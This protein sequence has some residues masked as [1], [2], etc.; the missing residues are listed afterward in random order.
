MSRTLSPKQLAANRANAKKSTGPRTREGKN[1]ASQNAR[2]H[3]VTAQTLILTDEAR[4]AYD[5]FFADMMVE[6]APVGPMETFIAQSIAQEA[7]RLDH[8]RA[9]CNN[10]I[11]IGHFD[12]TADLFDADHP[13]VH[14]A[15]TA[16]AVTRDQA[17][18]L[19]RLSLYQQ[20]IH[21][22]FQK[23]RA[24]LRKLQDERKAKRQAEL[25]EARR[26]SQLAKL[27]HLPY[28]PQ[29][30]GFDFSNDEIDRAIERHHRRTLAWGE[31]F[32]YW[33]ELSGNYRLPRSPKVVELKPELK[34]TDT[35]EAPLAA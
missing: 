23:H 1:R 19:E 4:K 6:L 10:L 22:S 16:A 21:S 31:D 20:R 32:T 24:D 2:N 3:G 28:E 15:V 12:G 9:Q 33:R 34:P 13:E 29:Q 8:V 14:T 25:E 27:K 18:K 35:P 26:M 5:A 17:E 30:D 7:W 11:A